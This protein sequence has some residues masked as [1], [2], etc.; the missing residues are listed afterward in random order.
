MP[1]QKSSVQCTTFLHRAGKQAGKT[2]GLEK[3][4]GRV[5]SNRPRTVLH[6]HFSWQNAVDG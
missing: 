5:I 2:E 1:V 4:E 3:D 6:M